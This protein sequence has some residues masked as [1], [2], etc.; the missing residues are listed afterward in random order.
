MTE[1]IEV[2]SAAF[3]HYA[4]L[5]RKADRTLSVDDGIAAGDAWAAFLNLFLAEDHQLPTR[6]RTRGNIAL[7]PS[8]K[9]RQPERGRP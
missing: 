4:E 2:Q 8:H 3:Q 6:A 7:F 9:A 1:P 5:K